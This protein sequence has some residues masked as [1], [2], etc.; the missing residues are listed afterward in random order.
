MLLKT[1]YRLVRIVLVCMSV[2]ALVSCKPPITTF[3]QTDYV[4]ETTTITKTIHQ[5]NSITTLTKIPD[6]EAIPIY[7]KDTTE[8]H[9]TAGNEF[10]IML[11]TQRMSEP[12][13]LEYYDEDSV[14]L[15]QRFYRD[16][17]IAKSRDGEEYFVFRAIGGDS[18]ITF[19][20]KYLHSDVVNSEITYQVFVTEK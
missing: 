8:I 15:T 6:W 14:I 7:G 10:A 3:T 17:G 2:F 5:P 9:V 19:I 16:T 18:E 1:S 12:V 20:Y 11:E 13:S 4:T